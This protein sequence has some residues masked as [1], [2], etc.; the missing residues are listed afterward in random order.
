MFGKLINGL[1]IWRYVAA[2]RASIALSPGMA[3]SDE[4]VVAL[5][6]IIHRESI[7]HGFRA[8]AQIKKIVFLSNQGSYEASFRVCT[9]RLSPAW[10]RPAAAV[11]SLMYRA[12]YST[13]KYAP[14]IRC[15]SHQ[16]SCVLLM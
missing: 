7:M 1:L 15:S 9:D 4:Q 8:Q 3:T 5:H 12:L 6:I 14:K 11:P 13:N 2:S 10:G 16:H